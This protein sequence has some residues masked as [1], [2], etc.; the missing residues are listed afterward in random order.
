M[1]VTLILNLFKLVFQQE[2]IQYSACN[3]LFLFLFRIRG[4]ENTVWTKARTIV[5]VLFFA[6]VKRRKLASHAEWIIRTH[7]YE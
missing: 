1:P 2:K 5:V 4:V 6:N 7:H 3:D